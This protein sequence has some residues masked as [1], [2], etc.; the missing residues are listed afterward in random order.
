[1]RTL[2]DEVEAFLYVEAEIC[3]RH[4]YSDWLDLWAE[5]GCY[6]V[7]CNDDDSDPATHVAITYETWRDQI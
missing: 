3:D 7:P 2:K 4:R 5:D 1:M 6:W